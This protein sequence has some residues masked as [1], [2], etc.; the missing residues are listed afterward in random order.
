MPVAAE[1][2]ISVLPNQSAPNI[3]KCVKTG[4]P[5]VGMTVLRE[6]LYVALCDS[7]LLALGPYCCTGPMQV[8]GLQTPC[9]QASSNVDG[10]LYVILVIYIIL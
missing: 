2:A 1:R 4:I 6:K 8:R 7:L 10:C 5:V 3:Y 9:G